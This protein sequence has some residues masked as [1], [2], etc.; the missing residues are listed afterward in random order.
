MPTSTTRSKVI[1]PLLA[2]LAVVS[3]ISCNSP[4]KEKATAFPVDLMALDPPSVPVTGVRPVERVVG[5]DFRW[6]TGPKASVSLDL[7]APKKLRLALSVS[8]PLQGQSVG[9]FLNGKEVARYENLPAVP[10]LTGFTPLEAVFDAP[11]GPSTLEI[12]FSRYNRRVPEDAFAPEDKDALAVTVR[13]FT[14]SQPSS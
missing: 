13:S 7:D 6:L 2:A 4:A 8:N 12:V 9:V 3:V 11:A 1:L 14:I 5:I 10:R